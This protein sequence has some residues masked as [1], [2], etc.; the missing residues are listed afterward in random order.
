VG[1]VVATVFGGCNFGTTEPDGPGCNL[2]VTDGLY[3]VRLHRPCSGAGCGP[4]SE[5]VFP[6]E[7]HRT[8][9][10]FLRIEGCNAT[11]CGGSWIIESTTQ[12]PGL[13][14]DQK[15]YALPCSV[16]FPGTSAACSAPSIEIRDENY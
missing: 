9:S 16:S 14:A 8:I 5:V 13:L 6:N 4:A 1:T 2:T 15:Q 3:T 7:I 11:Q 12:K 10:A